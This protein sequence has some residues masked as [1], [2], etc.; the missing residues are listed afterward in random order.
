MVSLQLTMLG[1]LPGCARPRGQLAPRERRRLPSLLS[2]MT[3]GEAHED[4]LQTRLARTQVQK[5]GA[6]VLNCIEQRGDSQVRLVYVQA[7]KAVVMTDGFDSWQRTPPIERSTIG[8]AADGKLHHVVPAEAIDQVGRR[9]F[10]D[11]LAV[12]DDGKAVAE[13]LSFVHIVRSEKH[14]AAVALEGADDIPELAAALWIK[15]R[16]GLIQKKNFGISHERSGDGKALAL[17][18]REL[19]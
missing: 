4:V 5:L 9:A 2:Q 17:S 6:L 15:T 11:D 8:V 14:R 7:N 19:S 10:G 1:V 12:V 3:A 16:G 13:A 18:A